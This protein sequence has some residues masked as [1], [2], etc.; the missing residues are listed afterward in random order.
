MTGPYQGP[1]PS[2]FAILTKAEAAASYTSSAAI[3]LV[4]SDF[5]IINI[6]S[7]SQS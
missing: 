4:R 1:Y 2:G 3:S 5:A 6:N 7:T